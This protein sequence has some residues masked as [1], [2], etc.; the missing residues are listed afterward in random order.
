MQFINYT[1]PF[2]QIRANFIKIEQLEEQL[3]KGINEL[4]EDQISNSSIILDELQER[5]DNIYRVIFE[6][7]PVSSD[8]RN[9]GIGGADRYADLKG[10]DNADLLI[11]TKKLGTLKPQYI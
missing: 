8:L 11:Q 4:L 3:K 5:D 2:E 1:T 9:A 6:S 10:Y 7:E